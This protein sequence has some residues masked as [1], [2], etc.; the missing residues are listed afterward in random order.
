MP[1]YKRVSVDDETA[2]RAGFPPPKPGRMVRDKNGVVWR[3]DNTP[4]ASSGA[5]E[6]LG[7]AWT[8][9]IPLGT[10][11]IGSIFG[12]SAASKQAEAIKTQAAA[13]VEIEQLRLQQAQASAP[14]WGLLIA[15]GLAAA[16]LMR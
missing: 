15:A 16:V 3:W 2:E 4:A 5:L 14:P 6:D 8:A 10:S 11:L 9:L 7:F 1:V 13:Q 12:A